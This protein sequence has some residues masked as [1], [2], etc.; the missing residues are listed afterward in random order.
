[1]ASQ[2]QKPIVLLIDDCPSM[3][4]LLAYKL[5][6]EG[7][8]FLAAFS[9]SEGFE[10]AHSQ[11]PSLI[12]LDYSPPDICGLDLLRRLKEDPR[13]H[14]IPV[15]MIAA[16]KS[17]QD[18][19]AAFETGAMDFVC[20]PVDV[21]ELRARM[22]SAIRLTRMMRT[23]EQRA[24]IDALTELGNRSRFNQKLS[25]EL[26]EASRHGTPMALALCDI[27]HFKRLNDSFGHPAGDDVLRT[28]SAILLRS[29][30][31]YDEAC[32]YGGEE[33]ALIFPNT[34][35]EE[36][37]G[38]CERIRKSLEAQHWTRYPDIRCTV[39]FG[40]TDRGAEGERDAPAWVEAADRALYAA[41]NSGRNCVLSY[42]PTRDARGAPYKRAG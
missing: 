1:M 17:S 23:L 14:T 20:K 4:R 28:F 22:Q 29:I 5:K 40:V 16:G 12:L 37:A 19:V 38:I 8:E 3:H 2:E 33:F 41:K 21:P 25:S 36:A 26:Q 18:Q 34:A 24:C 27:D 10:L 32:R 9:G 31:V 6:N 13:T 7:I 42:D 35:I 30:R 39:S 15:I 11:Q